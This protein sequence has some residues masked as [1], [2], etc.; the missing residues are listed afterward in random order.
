MRMLPDVGVCRPP[1]HL[2]RLVLPLPETPMTATTAEGPTSRSTP[3]RISRSPMVSRRS[4]T[5]TPTLIRSTI[6]HG[7]VAEHT[8]SHEVIGHVDQHDARHHR[9]DR[10]AAHSRRAPRG[11]QPLVTAHQ[12][13]DG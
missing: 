1:M 9:R 11:A 8:F 2:S 4:R 5:E 10:A 6:L 12:C 3:W 7:A 13:D